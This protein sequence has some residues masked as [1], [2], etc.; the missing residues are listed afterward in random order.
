MRF[1]TKKSLLQQLLRPRGSVFRLGLCLLLVRLRVHH[2][3]DDLPGVAGRIMVVRVCVHLLLA[4]IFSAVAGMHVLVN[5]V[6]VMFVLV[7]FD[8]RHCSAV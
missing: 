6:V 2:L 4:P 8:L 5:V 7:D 3:G 1:R